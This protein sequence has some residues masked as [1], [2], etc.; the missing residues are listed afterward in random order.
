MEKEK[1]G[2]EKMENALLKGGAAWDISQKGN[3]GKGK[4]KKQK[5]QGGK[6]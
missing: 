2:V 1:V 4:G 3:K 5:V 6:Q